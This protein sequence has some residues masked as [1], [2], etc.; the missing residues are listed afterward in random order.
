MVDETSGRK[1]SICKELLRI[2]EFR[3]QRQKKDNRHTICY[4]CEPEGGFGA[5][6]LVDALI[7]RDI[8]ADKIR[9]GEAKKIIESIVSD[10]TSFVNEEKAK[11][12]IVHAVEDNKNII[13][14][15]LM[16]ASSC[17]DIATQIQRSTWG[18]KGAEDLNLR[19]AKAKNNIVEAIRLLNLK[20]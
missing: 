18:E 6:K 19:A 8:E 13:D 17:A 4:D 16:L 3:F 9:D 1:C 2:D 11:N 20:W 5:R 7:S 12:N 15:F 10:N 14:H